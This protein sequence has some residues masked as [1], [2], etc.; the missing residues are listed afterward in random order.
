MHSHTLT[1]QF[2]LQYR[3]YTVQWYDSDDDEE[4]RTESHDHMFNQR[5]SNSS[6]SVTCISYH[7]TQHITSLVNQIDLTSLL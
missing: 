5:N 4:E 3:T 1:L 2:A 7:I 6:K